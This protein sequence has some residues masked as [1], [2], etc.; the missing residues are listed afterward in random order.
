MSDAPAV[1]A[2]PGIEAAR[3]APGYDALLKY[4]PT[5]GMLS[6]RVIA[7]TGAASGIGRA[8][9]FA[10]GR[11]GATLVVL[12]RHPRLVEKLRGELDAE[13]IGSVE[14]IPMDFTTATLAHYRK[15]AED[16]GAK[17]GRL[18][19]LVNNAGRIVELAPFEFVEPAVFSQVLA[20]NLI[21]PFFLTQWCVPLL[22]KAPD[23]VLVFS[24]DRAQ[25]AFWGAYGV[26]K[27][28]QEALLHILADE[29]HPGGASPMRV[30]GID[31]GPVSTPERRQHYP[32]E[33]IDAHPAPEDVV[34]PYLY[35]L[36]PDA[37]GLTDTVW[38]KP[39]AT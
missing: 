22:R 33:Q 11:L 39:S 34:G 38:R 36:G 27:A 25:R 13:G 7:I 8:V 2:A 5:P 16:I 17:Y 28:G 4:R 26:A 15:F 32:G 20:I 30:L 18:D 6:R 3:D 1:L 31:P 37:R 21:A 35:A 19:A 14:A 23:P 9:T 12:D 24:L 29:Y 10:A